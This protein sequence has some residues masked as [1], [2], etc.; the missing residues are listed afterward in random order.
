MRKSLL[1][2]DIEAQLKIETSFSPAGRPSSAV[3]LRFRTDF[4]GEQF[5]R[6]RE[7]ASGKGTSGKDPRDR[8]ERGERGRARQP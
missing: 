5:D 4:L 1:Q 3:Q 2:R 7:T 6:G 8:L